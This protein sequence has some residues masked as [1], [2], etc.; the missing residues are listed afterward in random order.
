MSSG[1]PLPRP[2]S[3]SR[4]ARWT[5]F[6]DLGACVLSNRRG[7]YRRARVTI[8]VCAPC[9]VGFCCLSP[10]CACFF[11]LFL[12]LVSPVARESFH[13]QRL[14]AR[15]D[16]VPLPRPPKAHQCSSV[17]LVFSSLPLKCES[18]Q[19][20]FSPVPSSVRALLGVLGGLARASRALLSDACSSDIYEGY[21]CILPKGTFFP[22]PKSCSPVVAS[23]SV[24]CS[25][26]PKLVIL[27]A[28]WFVF[29][30]FLNPSLTCQ[31]YCEEP[32]CLWA[33]R[34]CVCVCVCV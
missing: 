25:V 3:G 4:P 33:S 24:S 32:P 17:S 21:K 1:R 31:D 2:P 27:S 6:L 14:V 30:A 19:G 9:R 23:P 8:F 7:F 29:P 10:S 15:D 11:S 20:V 28:S 18:K 16:P 5:G 22:P 13:P 12:S 26:V 34:V